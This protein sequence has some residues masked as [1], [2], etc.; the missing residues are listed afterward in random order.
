MAYELKEILGDKT[1]LEIIDNTSHVP[2]IE[3][4]QEFNNIVL[5]FL[6]GS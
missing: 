3:C 2:Q 6:K 1:K 4:A 5:R